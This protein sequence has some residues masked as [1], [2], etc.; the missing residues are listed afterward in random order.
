MKTLFVSVFFLL[1]ATPVAF[2]KASGLDLDTALRDADLIARIKVISVAPAPAHSGF[3]HIAHAT[4]MDVAKGSKQGETIEIFSDNGLVC[5]NVIYSV[6]DD[7]I[8]FARRTKSGH[9]ETMNTYLGKFRIENGSTEFYLLPRFDPKLNQHDT[10]KQ[11][12]ADFKR[13]IPADAIMTE[14][15]RRLSNTTK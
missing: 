1:S 3:N 5:P 15:R 13:K 8:V 6:G 12:Q 10:P 9:F 2:P 7:C 14:L 4:V 11:I